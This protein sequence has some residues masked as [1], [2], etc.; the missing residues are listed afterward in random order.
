MEKGVKSAVDPFSRHA[1]YPL[2][3][4]NDDLIVQ[5][6]QKVGRSVEDVNT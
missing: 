2:I 3:T 4:M 6:K 1:R 5:I